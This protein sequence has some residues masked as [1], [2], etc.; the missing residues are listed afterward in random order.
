MFVSVSFWEKILCITFKPNIRTIFSKE[1]CNMINRF[2]FHDWCTIFSVE[3]WQWYT[4][5]TLP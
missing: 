3:D 5:N 2:F 1:I 4:P